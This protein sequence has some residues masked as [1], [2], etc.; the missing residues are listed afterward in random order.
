MVAEIL[1]QRLP[2]PAVVLPDIGPGVA[3]GIVLGELGV[4]SQFGKLCFDVCKSLFQF[5]VAGFHGVI[6]EV[7]VIEGLFEVIISA[8]EVGV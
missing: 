2:V 6:V 3:V 5:L 4:H 7:P 1:L 8:C